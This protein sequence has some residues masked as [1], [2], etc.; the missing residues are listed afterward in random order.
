MFTF[1]KLSNF[2]NKETITNY[3]NELKL[4]ESQLGKNYPLK[5]GNKIVSKKIKIPS[6]NPS[7]HKQV[8]GYLDAADISDIDN[9]IKVAKNTFLNWRYVDIDKKSNL[10]LNIAEKLKIKKYKF[11][12]LMT[13]EAGKSWIEADA[14][15]AEAIDFLKYYSEQIK[16]ISQ[17]KVGQ[18]E[19]FEH[20]EFRYIPL[21][22]GA[23]ITP[24]NFPLAILV[25]MIVSAII[26]GNT[27][28][29]KP[30]MT[31]G[32]IAHEFYD[33][34]IECGL[35]SGVVNLCYGDGPEIGKYLVKHPEISFI[36]FTGSKKVGLEIFHN[37]SKIYENQRHLKKV[38]AEMGGKDAIIADRDIDLDW[39]ADIIVKSAFGFSGQKCSACSR[40][41]IHEN[42]YDDLL[43]KLKSA[44]EKLVLGDPKNRNTFM[45]PL[46]DINAYN[47]VS[48]YILYGK[49]HNKILVGG[50]FDNSKGYFVSPTIFFDVKNDSIL[51]QEEIFGPLL[52][53]NKFKTIEEAVSLCNDSEYGL[54]GGI[55]SNNE[56]NINYVKENFQ[57]GNLYINRKCTGAIVGYQPFGGFKLSGTDS[58]AGGPNH[59]LLFVQ[60]QTIT[61]RK[62]DLK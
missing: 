15:V 60:G 7:N 44:T 1:E 42:V 19:D 62:G 41:Y 38:I 26:T 52:S 21:G 20:N 39:A 10:F 46:N 58:K 23:I 55:L 36:S 22:V 30:A 59:L 47:K 27:V 57:V 37:S 31:A 48:K 25:G 8:V 54:T 17:I 29:V 4:W 28:I 35:P 12:S 51:M 13:L 18:I 11:A 61:T 50:N 3:E 24:W 6:L 40:L 49:K 2:N 5:Y 53:V 9:A 16:S 34:M 56:F 33:L 32:V 14:D 43:I 45:G